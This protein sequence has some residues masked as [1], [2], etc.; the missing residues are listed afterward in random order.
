M[1]EN[2]L[3]KNVV[4]SED[5][6]K[7]TL[8]TGYLPSD[9]NKRVDRSQLLCQEKRG[10]NDKP[11]HDQAMTAILDKVFEYSCITKDQHTSVL[12]SLIK[13]DL[14]EIVQKRCV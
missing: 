7:E 12:G 11:Q 14:V 13:G 2:L 5:L 9:P 3:L 1:T 8:V 10:D 6:L 4:G